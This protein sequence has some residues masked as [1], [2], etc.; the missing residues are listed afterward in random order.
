MYVFLLVLQKRQ[1]Q[2]KMQ[3]EYRTFFYVLICV[4]F[5]IFLMES[6]VTFTQRLKHSAD[7]KND[8]CWI[9]EDLDRILEKVRETVN[10]HDSKVTT[11]NAQKQSQEV[12]VSNNSFKSATLQ[13][14]KRRKSVILLTQMRSGSSV[15]G[16][17]FNQKLGVP[18]FYEPVFPFGE[19][20]CNAQW[21]NRTQVV[22]EIA[23]CRFDKLKAL[24]ASGFE[25]TK[26]PDMF[27]R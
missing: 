5:T 21:Q 2:I 4:V 8:G 14:V 16:E 11:M 19:E 1:C 25:R 18:Y 22:E 9:E 13:N 7:D 10:T 3:R 6:N 17:L 15:I 20:P 24:Y 26:R 23:N 12:K 27:A